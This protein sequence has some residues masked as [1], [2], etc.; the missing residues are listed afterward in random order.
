[1]EE[2]NSLLVM[3]NISKGHLPGEVLENKAKPKAKPKAKK[4]AKKPA[5]VPAPETK[6]EPIET[7]T[8]EPETKQETKPEPIETPTPEQKTKHETQSE[9]EY[10]LEPI[11]EQ[12]PTT[13]PE[14]EEVPQEPSGETIIEFPRE[15]G[16]FEL[17]D[18][19]TEEDKVA[20]SIFNWISDNLLNITAVGL[21]ICLILSLISISALKEL[22]NTEEGPMTPFDAGYSA[23]IDSNGLRDDSQDTEI[24]KLKNE[25]DS[26]RKEIREDK[27]DVIRNNDQESDTDLSNS[28]IG[29]ASIQ[30]YNRMIDE[31]IEAA[32]AAAVVA[33]IDYRDVDRDADTK[34]SKSVLAAKHISDTDPLT[35]PKDCQ[36]F[37]KKAKRAADNWQFYIEKYKKGEVY[38]NTNEFS[39]AMKEI[40][41]LGGELERGQY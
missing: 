4:P 31:F 3:T 16:H 14:T 11:K 20:Q 21:I 2:G 25:V 23:V 5:A 29:I 38:N 6:P 28:P 15:E 35:V 17:S 24:N 39:A 7:P 1:M 40:N 27:S 41:A 10:K 19:V 37:H 12:S 34:I 32:T 36:M 26:L 30:E 13:E 33:P 22:K 18:N 8:T 9:P